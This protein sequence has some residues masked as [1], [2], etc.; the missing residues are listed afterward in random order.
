[1]IPEGFSKTTINY[2][3][4]EHNAIIQDVSGEIMVYLIAGENDPVMAVYNEEKSSF[5]IAEQIGISD[6][7]FVFVLSEG[8][9]STLPEQF[10]EANI[11]INGTNFP[12]WQNMNA[13]EYYLVY[14]LSSGG[15]KG[16]Y[17]Y[18]SI[19]GTYQRYVF[20]STEKAEKTK[21]DSPVLAKVKELVDHYFLIVAA[22]IAAL[23]LILFI[24]I[25]VLAVK[26]SRRN[27]ELDSFYDDYDD[28]DESGEEFSDDEYEDDD[29]YDNDEYEDNYDDEYDD[30]YDDDEYEDDYDDDEYEDDDD[31]DDDRK[32]KY[33]VDFIDL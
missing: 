23:L 24:V 12:A 1:M 4:G 14:A 11:E 6:E 29:G 25:I 16:Y 20:E 7:F 26:L 31:E 27:A 10:Q 19:E 15:T 17:E 28:D 32:Q 8:D 33:D 5:V 3:G 9:G 21:E 18:D 13:K 2:N 22:V 30:D